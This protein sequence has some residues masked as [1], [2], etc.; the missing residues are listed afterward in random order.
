MKSCISLEGNTKKPGVC[1]YRG[2]L[3][4]VREVMVKKIYSFL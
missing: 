4:V 1:L 2:K 3:S